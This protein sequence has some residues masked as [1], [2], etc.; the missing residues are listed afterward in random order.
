M[1]NDEL[2]R[3]HINQA[4][5]RP[6]LLLGCDRILL[7]ISGLACVWVIFN[8]GLANMKLAGFVCPIIAWFII[9]SGLRKMGKYDPLMRVVIQRAQGYNAGFMKPQYF[10]P[11]KGTVGS[12]IPSFV[13]KC[14][15]K[16]KSF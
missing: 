13:K 11:A 9:R 16:T 3:L 12:R 15:W 6:I 14:D 1:A 5:T 4:M 2:R 7:L 8:V 10:F